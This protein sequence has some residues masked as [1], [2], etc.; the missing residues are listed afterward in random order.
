MSTLRAITVLLLA[1]LLGGGSMAAQEGRFGQGHVRPQQGQW[2]NGGGGNA[3]RPGDWLVDHM[4]ESPAERERAL[5]NNPQ[6]R[7]LSPQRQQQL[8]EQLQR[9]NSR[10]PEEQ[11][12]IIERMKKWES[13]SPEQKQRAREAWAQFR[14]LPPGRKAALREGF[15]SL[16]G[17][18]PEERQRLLNSPAYKGMYSDQERD[19]M[20]SMTDLNIG[21]GANTNSNSAPSSGAAPR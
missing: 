6:F 13:W 5:E 12:K 20:R 11:A 2:R 17:L 1:S 18:S 19:V 4:K 14:D 7:N 15:R 16:Q 8:R 9:F 3:R 21:P 10:T